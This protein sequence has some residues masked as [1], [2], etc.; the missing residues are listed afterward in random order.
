MNNKKQKLTYEQNEALESVKE[1]LEVLSG[2]CD[3]GVNALWYSRRKDNDIV[4]R[5][6]T[7]THNPIDDELFEVGLPTLNVSHLIE[8]LE[9]DNLCM[10]EPD[11]YASEEEEEKA[12]EE[13]IEDRR[14][15][16]EDAVYDVIDEI[17][18]YLSNIEE[19]YEEYSE[20]D[21]EY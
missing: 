11:E 15:E 19:N 5:L 20:D 9:D 3:R 13:Y 18:T 14:E 21:E 6:Y 10:W 2:V 1:I 16:I 7:H 4:S 12:L 17:E 8:E